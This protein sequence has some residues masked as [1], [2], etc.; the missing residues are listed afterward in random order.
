MGLAIVIT[1]FGLFIQDLKLTM[2]EGTNT[3]CVQKVTSLLDFKIV[4]QCLSKVTGLLEI[5]LKIFKKF[6]FWVFIILFVFFHLGKKF[7]CCCF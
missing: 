3:K 4:K 6:A 2:K 5:L 7:G 1:L